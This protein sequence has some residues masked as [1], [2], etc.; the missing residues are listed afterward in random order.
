MSEMF[1]SKYKPARDWAPLLNKGGEAGFSPLK[2]ETPAIPAATSPAPAQKPAEVPIA[3]QTPLDTLG[4]ASRRPT[5]LS[6][7]REGVASAAA[8]YLGTKLG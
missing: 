6:A 7:G 1:G 8:S 4:K 5:I 3:Q 2:P